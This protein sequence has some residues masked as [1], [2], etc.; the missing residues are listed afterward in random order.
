VEDLLPSGSYLTGAADRVDLLSNIM[1]YFERPPEGPGTGVDDEI[2]VHL[3]HACPNPFG[4]STI[5]SFT[6]DATGRARACVYDLTGRLVKT[7]LDEDVEAGSRQLSWDGTGQGG[8][9]V[10][11]GVY[12]VR[13]E[14]PGFSATRKLVLLR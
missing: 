8:A 10:A 5:I 9:T 1:E 6:V 7:L 4:P 3:D 14:C 11:S 12:F 2:V 13:V